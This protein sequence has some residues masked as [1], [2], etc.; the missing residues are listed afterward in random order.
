MKKRREISRRGFL[1]GMAGGAAAV[2]TSKISLAAGGGP[3]G[4]LSI[5]II[6]VSGRAEE[7]LKAVRGEEIVAICDIDDTYLDNVAK[8]FPSATRYNDFRKLLDQKGIDA[9]VVSTPDHTHAAATLRALRSGR[10]VY[11]EKPLA[12]TVHEARAVA[13]AAAQSGKATQLG[14]QIHAEPNYRR[15]V[16]LVR[17]GAIGAVREVHVWVG[18]TWSGGERPKETPPCPPHIH[19]DLWLGPAPERPYHPAY[20]P[21]NWRRWWDFGGGT[22]A[23]MACHHMDLPQWAL[24]LRHPVSVEAEG[25][26]VHP[27]TTPEWLIVHYEH[28]ARGNQ[29]PVVVTWYDGGK[30]PPLFGQKKLPQWGDGVL[31]VGDKGLL[32][33]DYGRHKL[34]PESDFAGFNHPPKTIPDSPGHH[35]EWIRAAK[36]GSP[37][38]CNFD[39]GGALTEMALLGNVAF[40]TGKKIRWDAEKLECT[41]CPDASKFLRSQPR[42]GWEI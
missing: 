38:L 37:T 33:S 36:T 10:H 40:R 15:V 8:E 14:T 35:E 9:V 20:L 25:P 13:K 32:L 30:R 26:P 29:P 16:E 6:G 3:S 17:S 4:K 12:H 34:L 5:G 22:L 21:A 31:F 2:W 27:E 39:Y 42:K 28:P 11:C 18:K 7:N 19:F 23:D 1:A 24:D 41:G